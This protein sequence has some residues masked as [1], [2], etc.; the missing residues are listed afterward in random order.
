MKAW[1][2]PGLDSILHELYTHGGLAVK[3]RLFVLV[4]R[5]WEEKAVPKDPMNA[6]IVAILRRG[7]QK[8]YGHYHGISL[9]SVA[10]EIFGRILID[11]FIKVTEEIV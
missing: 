7:S 8:D 1:K 3:T 5:I 4:L 10:G 9:L 6:L 2:G 11:G